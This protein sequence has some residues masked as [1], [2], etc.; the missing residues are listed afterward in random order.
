MKIFFLALILILITSCA[1]EPQKSSLLGACLQTKSDAF[2]W[3]AYDNIY[4]GELLLSQD[5]PNKLIRSSEPI[6]KIDAETT[7]QLVSVLRG[8]NGSY[9]DFLRAR[10]QV[11]DGE[12]LGLV[13][14]IPAC[15]PYHPVLRWITSCSLDANALTFNDQ[16]L[17]VCNE[18]VPK[19]LGSKEL[20][21]DSN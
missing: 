11:L 19:E 20:G 13:A 5:E 17:E 3:S 4:V 12:H 1:T 15:V 16:I 7:L 9:G 2:I 18:F 10:V 6:G 8:S 21:S 14:D